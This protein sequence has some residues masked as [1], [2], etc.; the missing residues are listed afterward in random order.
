[1]LVCKNHSDD[2]KFCCALETSLPLVGL[3][4]FTREPRK[5][6]PASVL[7]QHILE[8]PCFQTFP[9]QIN[10]FQMSFQFYA[11]EPFLS[12]VSSSGS[13]SRAPVENLRLCF[14]CA[15]LTA[16]PA[17]LPLPFC[18]VRSFNLSHA[19]SSP[20]CTFLI[21]SP[22]FSILSLYFNLI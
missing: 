6:L 13:H 11:L 8:A 22:P 9:F 5:T 14:S 19:F 21:L 7:Q 3:C 20:R 10:S 18:P 16:T 15:A 1:M 17:L 2:T 4:A 12:V